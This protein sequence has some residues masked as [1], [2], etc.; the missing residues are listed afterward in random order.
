MQLWQLPATLNRYPV[1]VAPISEINSDVDGFAS[2][3]GLCGGGDTTVA[4]VDAL[5]GERCGSGRSSRVG[6]GGGVSTLAA[7]TAEVPVVAVTSSPAQS[8]GLPHARQ[9]VFGVQLHSKIRIA[10]SLRN[11]CPR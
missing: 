2:S 6:G 8:C 7:R 3:G 1:R 11:F 10:Q 9:P 4:T 5:L